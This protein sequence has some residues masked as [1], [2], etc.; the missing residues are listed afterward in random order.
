MSFK[1]WIANLVLDGFKEI[2]E[3]SENEECDCDECRAER[4]KA[5]IG[6]PGPTQ[7]EID[8]WVPPA[9]FLIHAGG[10]DYWIDSWKSGPAGAIDV[11]WTQKIK[12]EEKT[13]FATIFESSFTIVD[14]DSP[15]TMEAFEHV[16]KQSIE[17]IT[18]LANEMKA[19]ED[20]K[21]KKD[22]IPPEDV[23][24]AAYM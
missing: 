7:D 24:L 4:E 5:Q 6:Y 12:G 16:K 2:E 10:V 15:M 3:N 22:Q 21:K 1:T 13:I 20:A 9:R 8:N 17:Y 14:Y 18:Q 23:S 11:C 19:T